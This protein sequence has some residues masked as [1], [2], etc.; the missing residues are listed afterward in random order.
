MTNVLYEGSK[1]ICVVCSQE[2]EWNK[3]T[4]SWDCDTCQEAYEGDYDPSLDGHYLKI[5]DL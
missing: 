2:V 1:I 5:Y 3:E 4:Q